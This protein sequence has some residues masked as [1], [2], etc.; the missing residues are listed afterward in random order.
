MTDNVIARSLLAAALIAPL[1]VAGPSFGAELARTTGAELARTTGT[2]T[3][4][5]APQPDLLPGVD[6]YNDRNE[7]LG[8]IERVVTRNG[9]NMA[10]AAAGKG[11]SRVAGI[12]IAVPVERFYVADKKI[13]V[14]MSRAAF[15]RGNA[16]GAS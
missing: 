12:L 15:L 2:D 16:A 13:T 6:V 5:P 4:A 7:L 11:A 3:A 8:T 14:R 10:L 9:S 1:V